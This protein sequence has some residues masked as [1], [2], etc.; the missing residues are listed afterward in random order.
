MYVIKWRNPWSKKYWN[1]VFTGLS[2]YPNRQ[3]ADEQIQRFRSV[4][5]ENEY[6]IEPA[7]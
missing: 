7:N 1:T 3:A 5:R 6:Y 4:G 2:R